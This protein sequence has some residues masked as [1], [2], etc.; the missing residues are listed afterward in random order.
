MLDRCVLADA[1]AQV[2]HM[3]TAGETIKDTQRLPLQLVATGKQQ[4]G[5]E[6]ALHRQAIRQGPGR[7]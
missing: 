6:I 5:I 3:R 4:Q 1:M 7:P 2:E